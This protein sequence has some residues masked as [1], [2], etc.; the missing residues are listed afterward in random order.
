MSAVF[1]LSPVASYFPGRSARW[2][3]DSC[4]AGR[5][6]GAFKVG[7][8]WFI[9]PGDVEALGS[10]APQGAPTVDDALADLR[11]RGVR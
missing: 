10:G 7:K 3:A 4:R 2:V 5:V 9:R 6:P 8:S 1:A 11:R